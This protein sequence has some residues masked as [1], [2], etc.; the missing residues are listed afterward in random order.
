MNKIKALFSRVWRKIT[1]AVASL[2]AVFGIY[3]AQ[4]QATEGVLTARWGAVTTATDG[5]TIPANELCYQVYVAQEGGTIF[6]PANKVG[7]CQTEL[8]LEIAALTPAT[9]YCAVVTAKHIP[10][11]TESAPGAQACAA[12]R[13]TV[14]TPVAPTNITLE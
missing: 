14:R 10:S 8:M 9:R 3:V 2:L 4:G 11:N 12:A 13:A 5:S 7:T 1:A 6:A